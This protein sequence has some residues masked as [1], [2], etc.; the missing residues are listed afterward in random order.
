M[1][2][3]LSTHLIVNG[4]LSRHDSFLTIRNT[5]ATEPGMEGGEL[6]VEK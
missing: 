1:I 3:I 4:W 5:C 6:K 2:R